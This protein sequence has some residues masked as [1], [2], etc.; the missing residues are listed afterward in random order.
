MIYFE[1][2][3]YQVIG[4]PNSNGIEKYASRVHDVPGHL[5]RLDRTTVKYHAIHGAKRSLR[6][7]SQ[8]SREGRSFDFVNPTKRY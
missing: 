2:L 6:A 5:V 1:D 7:M 4:L 8:A 3:L